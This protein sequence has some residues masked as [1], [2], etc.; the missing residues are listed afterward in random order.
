MDARLPTLAVL[1][2]A[3]CAPTARQ[4]ECDPV[5]QDGCS[6]GQRCVVAAHGEP[7]CV[8]GEAGVKVLG[9]A[10]ERPADCLAGRGCVEIDGRATCLAFCDPDTPEGLGTCQPRPDEMPS[11]EMPP[12]RCLAAV[13]GHPE[14][15]VCV[16]ECREPFDPGLSCGPA[17]FASAC[18][19]PAGLD[20]AVCSGVPG[21]AA[22]GAPCGPDRR[23]DADGGLLCVPLG[24]G[25]RCRRAGPCPEG[26]AGFELPFPGAPRYP[27][28]VP[29]R[30]VSGPVTQLDTGLALG[31]ADDTRAIVCAPLEDE[32]TARSRCEAEGGE[33]V[34]R[35][36]EAAPVLVEAAARVADGPFQLRGGCMD[37]EGAPVSCEAGHALCLISTAL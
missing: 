27:V 11:A 21:D 30:V 22:E 36:V 23:C 24:D 35:G 34:S 25:A 32:A 5:A 31:A 4:A 9:A 20:V 26:E 17:P 28:C 1:I 19:I 10:C 8:G 33:L 7:D 12:A 2:A 13:E 14:I 6:K 16:P 3:A 29:C 18:W 15:G 37:A